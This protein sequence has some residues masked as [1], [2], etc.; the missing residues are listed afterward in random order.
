MYSDNFLNMNKSRKVN[1]YT[2]FPNSKEWRDN[3]FKGTIEDIGND[4]ILL[5]D[6]MTN[7]RIM[8]YTMF[9]DYIV[10]EE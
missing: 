9:I 3:I 8:I 1:I 10:I 4:Y 7:K 6:S 5:K 2:T